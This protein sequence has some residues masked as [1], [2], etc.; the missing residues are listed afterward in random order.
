MLL[1]WDVVW[2]ECDNGL[3]QLLFYKGIKP[4]SLVLSCVVFI[5]KE[6]SIS[7]QVVHCVSLRGNLLMK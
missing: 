4:L 2:I 1:T 3:N 5:F 7:L 6:D